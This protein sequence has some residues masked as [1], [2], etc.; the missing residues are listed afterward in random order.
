M[1]KMEFLQ[2]PDVHGFIQWLA[3]DL[4]S[5]TFQL[6]LARSRFVPGG[7]RENVEGVEEVLKHYRWHARWSD[8]RSG[9]DVKSANWIETKGS[10]SKLRGWLTESV[11]SANQEQTLAAS[12][13]VL[14]WGGVRGAREFLD[15][16]CRAKKLV[17]HL[18]T[19][20]ALL[21][22]NGPP[23][24]RI[25]DVTAAKIKKFDSGLTK[26]HALLDGDGSPIYDS[27]VAG[28]ISLLYTL[29]RETCPASVE[30]ALEFPCGTA[31]GDQLRNPGDLGFKRAKVL[32][33]ETAHHEWA[34]V[35]LKLGWLFWGLLTKSPG[36]FAK[37]GDLQARAHALEASLFMVGYDLRCFRVQPSKGLKRKTRAQ[38]PKVHNFGMVPTMHPFEKVVNE[39]I[40]TRRMRTLTSQQDYYS[41]MFK[42][43]VL[44]PSTKKAYLFPLKETE[45]N[46]CALRDESIEELDN[47]RH[48]WLKNYFEPR[49]FELP[50]E[51]RYVCL[52]DAWL[53]G[54]L[55][56]YFEKTQHLKILQKAGFAGTN[57]AAS[58]L[59]SVGRSVGK[60]FSLL[61][62]HGL[63]TENFDDFYIDMEELKRMLPSKPRFE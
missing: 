61:D 2:N 20:Q 63:P 19:V 51:R 11:Q 60:F 10:L 35:Q 50:D 34:Q 30:G 28:A 18:R 56:R 57:N 1:N 32:Y 37:E 27:R 24:Q 42:G 22:V 23:T 43:K 31:R 16:L 14:Q 4:I 47:D 54:H 55:N 26:I 44:K 21:A 58:G 53:V 9:Q 13:A 52:I 25:E 40:R 8:T 59:L 7:L 46:L 36:L 17:A 12:K 41:E 49:G 39:F 6:D 15:E 62:E 5:R 29:F 33:S 48:K 38:A 45:F 3:S